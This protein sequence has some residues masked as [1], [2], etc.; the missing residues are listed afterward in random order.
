MP[1]PPQDP[2]GMI[3]SLTD[4]VFIN[5]NENP[6]GPGESALRALAGLESWAGAMAFR[7]PRGSPR[8]SPRRTG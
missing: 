5:A 2:A 4:G 7:C 8:C 6:L 3:A 1:L